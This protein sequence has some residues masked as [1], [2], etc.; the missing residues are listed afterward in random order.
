MNEL[1]EE[2]D[3]LFHFTD[4]EK[5]S[6][7]RENEKKE[8]ERAKQLASL[9]PHEIAEIATPIPCDIPPYLIRI[10]ELEEYHGYKFKDVPRP[11]CLPRKQLC[12]NLFQGIDTRSFRYSL[13]QIA[14]RSM[15]LDFGEASGD[16][17]KLTSNL[18]S[19]N[20]PE[21]DASEGFMIIY[22]ALAFSDTFFYLMCLWCEDQVAFLEH[23]RPIIESLI[24]VVFSG[25]MNA[26]GV[27]PHWFTPE[28]AKI[29]RS[30][31]GLCVACTRAYSVLV[32]TDTNFS[33]DSP[34]MTR[35][36][37]SSSSFSSSSS[38]S[39]V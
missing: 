4:D 18:C 21:A 37:S 26:R 20:N 36:S 15:E 9:G 8:E 35:T 24:L 34:E 13:V 6:T 29:F 23:M 3:E 19:P 31:F 17:K 16:F 39:S 28:Y 11:H 30:C 32:T 22:S 38:S 7:E 10:A 2:D 27:Y 33:L 14:I 1:F 12:S 5:E 25:R